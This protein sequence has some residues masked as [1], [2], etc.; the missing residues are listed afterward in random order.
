MKETISPD[1]YVYHLPV[2]QASNTEDRELEK[3]NIAN[4]TISWIS[5]LDIFI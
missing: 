4:E 2:C 1:G 3:I 5:T